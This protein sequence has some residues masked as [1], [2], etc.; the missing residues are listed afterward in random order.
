MTH[1][2][3][4]PAQ[5]RRFRDQARGY[6][7]FEAVA[8]IH[9]A[10]E[11]LLRAEPAAAA[12][13][14]VQQ[15]LATGLPPSARSNAALLALL[16]LRLG[17]RYELAVQ[18]LDDALRRAREEG[19]ATRQGILH[20]QRTEPEATGSDAIAAAARQIAD[21][22]DL[23]A[24]VCW[25]FSG[26]TALRVARERPKSPVVAISPNVATG[27]KLSLVWGG[28]CVVAEDAHDQDDMLVRACR[29]AFS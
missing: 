3:G 29:I 27:R 16:A 6:P 4:L 11:Q 10:Y 28:H 8:S 12:M 26:S 9:S 7:G 14:Q 18:L 5:L 19:H 15:A 13:D 1:S 25:T 2:S 21:T 20:A 17:E 22:L 23:A 24:V